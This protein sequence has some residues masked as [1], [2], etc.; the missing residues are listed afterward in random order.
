MSGMPSKERQAFEVDGFEYVLV[1]P[2]AGK[3]GLAL[4]SGHIPNHGPI[5]GLYRQHDPFERWEDYTPGVEILDDVD[6]GI[7]GFRL[8]REVLGR[9]NGWVNRA[10][11]SYFII[12]PSTERK[13]PIYARICNSLARR[14]H[15]YHCQQI[16]KSFYF[17][18]LA[19][20][21]VEAVAEQNAPE[22]MSD[23]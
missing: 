5:R 22:A 16:G 7:N 21:G 9:I 18:R 12:S 19:T 8:M 15:G 14:I 20:N 11:P 3:I 23:A 1:L 17:F 2:E 13:A 10:R 6:I 4:T